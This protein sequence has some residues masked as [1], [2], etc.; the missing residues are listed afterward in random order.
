MRPAY[1]ASKAGIVYLTKSVAAQYGRRGIRCNAVAP[2]PIRTPATAFFTSEEVS[3]LES[4][5]LT[6]R[7]GE[8]EDIAAAVAFLADATQSGFVCGHVL[9]VDGGRTVPYLGGLDL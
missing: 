4:Y 2:G 8:P 7:L 1:G 5:T 3:R 9:L 6:G